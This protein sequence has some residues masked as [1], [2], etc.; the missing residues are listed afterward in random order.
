MIK[1]G[2]QTNIQVDTEEDNIPYCQ[3]KFFDQTKDVAHISPYG[4]FGSPPL[5]S[6]WV[7]F[8]LR[9]NPDD[10]VGF[11]ND[12]ANRPKDLKEGEL[13][14]I[15]T[16]TRTMIK[17]DENGDF[18]I[19]SNNDLNINV[20]SSVNV[21]AQDSISLSCANQVYIEAGLGDVSIFAD[22]EID[23]TTNGSLDVNA[24]GDV[25]IKAEQTIWMT[26]E[27]PTYITATGDLRLRSF[28]GNCNIQ[29]TNSNVN[30]VA[31]D[32]IN[33]T[34]ENITLTANND[35]D[36]TCQNNITLY[37]DSGQIYLESDADT[38]IYSYSDV[39]LTAEGSVNI[40]SSGAGLSEEIKLIANNNITVTANNECNITS[41]NN[42]NITSSG[43]DVNLT[44]TTGEIKLS[45]VDDL[46]IFCDNTIDVSC[47][48]R[49]YIQSGLDDVVIESDFDIILNPSREVV[50]N[51]DLTVNGDIEAGYVTG[52]SGLLTPNDVNI[53]G[54][55][56]SSS[57]SSVNNHTHVAP[58]GG[59]E[60]SGPS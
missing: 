23:L 37:S 10:M 20:D 33:L 15:N 38:T 29:A 24:S 1:A 9:N 35:I 56:V 14:L 21:T 7:V 19:Y 42:C 27:G 39:N 36:I 12:Y 6:K 2:K 25:N 48:N 49:L 34:G 16:K 31:D 58:D 59:G 47:A 22:T 41:T 54:D 4:L 3:I 51:G 5:E 43:G 26:S 18:E 30:I 45:A 40:T 11:G 55:F 28:S 46:N 53:D 60:T 52:N 17:F 50:I 13:A 44:S 32:N 8:P 57:L